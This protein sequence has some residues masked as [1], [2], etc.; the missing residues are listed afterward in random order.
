M[1]GLFVE[2]VK[3]S[4]KKHIVDKIDDVRSMRLTCTNADRVFMDGKLESYLEMYR[5]LSEETV[6]NVN[7]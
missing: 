6:E 3:L 5:F 1:R 7:N 4:L 2:D